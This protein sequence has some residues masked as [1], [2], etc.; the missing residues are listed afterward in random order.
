MN[1][2]PCADELALE[3][4]DVAPLLPEA[5]QRGE[6]SSETD[7]AVRHVSNKLDQMSGQQNSHLWTPD[8]LANSEHWETVR[9]LASEALGKLERFEH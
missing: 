9:L 7:L 4:D 8:A 1:V 3:L 5:L 2:W 6:I